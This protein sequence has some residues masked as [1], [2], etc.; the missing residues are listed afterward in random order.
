[1]RAP[2]AEASTR[3]VDA[4][5]QNQVQGLLGATTIT[6]LFFLVSTVKGAKPARERVEALLSLFEIAAVNRR[7]LDVH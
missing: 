1:M 4:H 2:F 6:T 3:A 7:G 5:V